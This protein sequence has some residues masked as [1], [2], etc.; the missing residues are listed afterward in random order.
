MKYCQTGKDH[1]IFY[2]CSKRNN[3]KLKV[4]P[5]VY[6]SEYKITST[7]ITMPFNLKFN[8]DEIQ[9]DEKETLVYEIS[10]ELL[11]FCTL[12]FTSASVVNGESLTID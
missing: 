6:L 10:E 1:L 5:S 8:F 12:I 7:D 9:K 3:K 11:S 2:T 4:H